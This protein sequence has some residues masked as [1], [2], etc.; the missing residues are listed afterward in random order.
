MHDEVDALYSYRPEHELH[1][2]LVNGLT[3]LAYGVIHNYRDLVDLPAKLR[4]VPGATQKHLV[5]LTRLAFS[6]GPLLEADIDDDTVEMAHAMLED[7]LNPEE[8]EA[9]EEALRGKTQ[10]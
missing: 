2:A 3:R 6:E 4:I 9:L 7:A 10:E 5:V 8:A 1:I